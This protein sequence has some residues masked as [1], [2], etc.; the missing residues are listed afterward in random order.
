MTD[1]L[2]DLDGA[3]EKLHAELFTLKGYA[4]LDALIAEVRAARAGLADAEERAWQDV[5]PCHYAI[6][7]EQGMGLHPVYCSVPRRYH[8]NKG[9]EFKPPKP[10]KS[11]FLT[12]APETRATPPADEVAGLT[13]AER[14]VLSVARTYAANPTDMNGILLLKFAEEL[15]ENHLK[16]KR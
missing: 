8:F 12:D 2:V 13:E 4:L 10:I 5:Q 9:H 15:R 3:F 11:E 14:D 1:A 7:A 6:D 16:G